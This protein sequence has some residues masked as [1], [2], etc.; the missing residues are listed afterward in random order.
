[1]LVERENIR[2]SNESLRVKLARYVSKGFLKKTGR[3]RYQFTQRGQLFF[4][5]LGEPR[6]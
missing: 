1:M 3:A 2:I 6:E 5:L 4:D